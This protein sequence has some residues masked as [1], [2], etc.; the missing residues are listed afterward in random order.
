MFKQKKKNTGI[1]PPKPPTSGLN[2]T[3]PLREFH[4][5]RNEDGTYKLEVVVEYYDKK[6]DLMEAH[7]VYPRTKIESKD[8]VLKS[9]GE[10]FVVNIED[11]D[12]YVTI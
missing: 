2:T 9:T 10:L 8:F 1:K 6:S 7:I 12:E 4:A 3:K 5:H 11:G